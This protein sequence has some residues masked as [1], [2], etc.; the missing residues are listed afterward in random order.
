MTSGASKVSLR[1]V[2]LA[3]NL[4]SACLRSRISSSRSSARFRAHVDLPLP[5]ELDL[6]VEAFE[7]G[8]GFQPAGDVAKDAG[9]DWPVVG[10]TDRDGELRRELGPVRLHGDDFDDFSEPRPVTGRG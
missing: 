7:L 3:S 4:G 9:E 8:L 2:P 10:L 1:P 6:V 5:L